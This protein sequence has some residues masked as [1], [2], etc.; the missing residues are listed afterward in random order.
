MIRKEEFYRETADKPTRQRMWSAIRREIHPPRAAMFAIG[1]LRS[2]CYGGIAAALLY[3]AGV[4][5]VATVRERANDAKPRAVRLDE[6]YQSAIEDFEKIVPA[7]AT[8]GA[9]APNGGSYV[10][11]R[12]QQLASISAAIA[13]LKSEMQLGDLSPLKQQRLRQLY[14]MKLT[15]LQQLIDQGEFEL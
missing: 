10:E 7:M 8:G 1:D 11:G 14:G 5:L 9:T 12:K 15:V 13:A 4:G 3:F 6:A 2:F